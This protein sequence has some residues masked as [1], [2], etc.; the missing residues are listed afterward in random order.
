MCPNCGYG[1]VNESRLIRR[2]FHSCPRCGQKFNPPI[3]VGDANESTTVPNQ[4][5][6]YKPI[7]E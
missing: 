7:V 2:V 4:S 1:F 5:R 6:P 3:T